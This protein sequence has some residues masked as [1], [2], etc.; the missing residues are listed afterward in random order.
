MEEY[1][2]TLFSRRK[3]NQRRDNIALDD[4]VLIVD[5]FLPRGQWPMGRVVKLYPDSVGVVRVVDVKSSNG[6]LRRSISKL[7]VIVRADCEEKTNEVSSP[8]EV[9][10]DTPA[11][12]AAFNNRVSQ[13]DH[14]R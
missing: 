8:D 6:I 10:D 14:D 1:P 4:I 9:S 13:E 7:C 12:V 3:W 5:T 11:D 2:R